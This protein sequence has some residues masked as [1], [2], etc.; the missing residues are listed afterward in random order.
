MATPARS[1]PCLTTAGDRTLCHLR[2]TARSLACWVPAAGARVSWT[3]LSATSLG[4]SANQAHTTPLPITLTVTQ[5]PPMLRLRRR[6]V[7]SP[8]GASWQ[9]AIWRG[10]AG[11]TSHPPAPSWSPCCG[12]A[13]LEASMPNQ[14]MMLAPLGL[15]PG[16]WQ[17]RPRSHHACGDD[18]RAAGHRRAHGRIPR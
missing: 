3:M 11:G 7:P 4:T 5:E 16:G 15:L 18:R 2:R 10:S 13:T 1:P 6:R 12:P 9:L 8:R 17:P 14:V